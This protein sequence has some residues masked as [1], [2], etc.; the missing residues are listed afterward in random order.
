MDGGNQLQNWLL[1]SSD[2]CASIKDL[3]K[4]RSRWFVLRSKLLRFMQAKHSSYP[5]ERAIIQQKNSQV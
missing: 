4:Q 2:T 5:M 1:G 3:P